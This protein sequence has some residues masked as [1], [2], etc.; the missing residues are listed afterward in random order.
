M[1]NTEKN[2]GDVVVIHGNKLGMVVDLGNPNE[3]WKNRT[4]GIFPLKVTQW[5]HPDNWADLENEQNTVS[6]TVN[7]T[8]YW[9]YTVEELKTE[10]RERQMTI[11][12]SANKADLVV[13][14]E[15]NDAR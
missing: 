1:A 6:E 4:L 14:L 11:P 15:Q 8:N 9:D 12:A 3:E 7:T 13:L 10:L 5:V 2:L